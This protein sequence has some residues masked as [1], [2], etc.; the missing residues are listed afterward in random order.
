MSSLSM[1]AGMLLAYAGLGAISRAMDRHHADLHGR[2][3][4][5]NARLRTRC[6]LLGWAGI[7]ASFAACIASHG[8]HAG[9]VLWCGALTASAF[10]LTLL[11]QYAPRHALGLSVLGPALALMCAARRWSMSLPG[12]VRQSAEPGAVMPSDH[13]PDRA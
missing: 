5:I 7:A 3:A 10:L 4:G 9:P 2:G 13:G 6:R 11:L 1:P 8:W 12:Q